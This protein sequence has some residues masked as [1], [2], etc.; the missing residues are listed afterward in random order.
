MPEV[1][2]GSKR[3]PASSWRICPATRVQLTQS[4]P[5]CMVAAWRFT[6]PQHPPPAFPARVPLPQDPPCP[7]VLVP[8]PGSTSITV[9]REPALAM[10]CHGRCQ[11]ELPWTPTPTTLGSTLVPQCRINHR[12][13][14]LM[15]MLKPL[16]ILLSSLLLEAFKNSPRFC[17]NP[18]PGVPNEHAG[19]QLV[20]RVSSYVHCS[21]VEPAQS[22]VGR[23]WQPA[24]AL[25][26]RGQER[27]EEEPQGHCLRHTKTRA[28]AAPWSWAQTWLSRESRKQQHPQPHR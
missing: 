20:L 4:M 22:S 26:Q 21:R 16:H 9:L 27:G 8:A 1:E 5:C 12:S 11:E 6:S 10:G 7:H 13:P 18:V 25:L 3:D 19:A 23:I 2:M 24:P 15:V 14:H 28:G 17:F